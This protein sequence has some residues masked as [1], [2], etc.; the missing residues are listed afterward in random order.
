MENRFLNR[1]NNLVVIKI[2]TRNMDRFLTNLYKLNIDIFNV[3]VVNFKEVIVEIYEKDINK[4]KK[5]SILNKI[6]VI[7]Y[8]GKIK[9]KKK[10]L[11]NKTLLFS[12]FIGLIFLYFLSNI[13]F[14]IEVVHTSS[15][16]R[17]FIMEELKENGNHKLQFRK[18][19]DKISKLKN[20]IL[21]NNKDVLEWLE[22]ERVGT[23]YVVKLEERKINSI[24]SN[25]KNQDIVS[26]HDAVI[27]KII[28]K[29][30]VK[31]K[32]VNE[33]VKKGDTV[34]SG[35]IYLNEEIKEITKALGEIYGEVWY[36]ISVEYPII[37]EYEFETGNKKEVISV[38]FFNKN[39]IIF[40]NNPYKSTK[41]KRKYILKNNILPISISKD[42]IYELKSYSGIYVEGE[43]VINAKDYAR[44]KIEE[45]LK[46]DEYI[47]SEKVLKYSTNSNTI[48]IDM[49]YK[50]YKNITGTKEIIIEEGE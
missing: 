19:F 34:I 50:I 10:I 4:I 32:E 27:K 11:F 1:F 35:T 37:K 12:L 16:V 31:V 13:I 45:T 25:Y 8:K 44:R 24:S 46:N 21:E 33:Y 23:K 42:T 18:N 5:L 38:N 9:S 7:D 17:N 14:S 29:S 22:I 2:K 41:V 20:K 36:K 3:N 28:A 48:Y 40:N 49:F 47:I 26:T 30:G 43:A 39:F 6:D 15:E